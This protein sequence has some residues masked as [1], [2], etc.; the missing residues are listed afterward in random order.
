MDWSPLCVCVLG[1]G[2]HQLRIGERLL[3]V[4]LLSQMHEQTGLATRRWL[5]CSQVCSRALRFCWETFANL[6]IVIYSFAAICLYCRI[7][8]DPS[9]V[10]ILLAYTEL[11]CFPY[12]NLILSKWA[13]WHSFKPFF[14]SFWPT[15]DNIGRSTGISNP[16]MT[17]FAGGAKVTGSVHPQP[18]L[19]N[20]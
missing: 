2:Q 6:R 1:K 9:H 10:L 15:K 19:P 3:K 13:N 11:D 8:Y 17:S 20:C 12:H 14:Q 5:S 7:C 4:I 16:V 18:T